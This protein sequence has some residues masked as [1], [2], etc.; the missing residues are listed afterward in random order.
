MR[1]IPH[2]DG[3]FREIPATALIV[4]NFYAFLKA[5]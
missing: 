1:K 5:K 3:K 2:F 4:S